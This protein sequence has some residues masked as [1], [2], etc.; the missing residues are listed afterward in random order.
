MGK[1]RAKVVRREREP[2][3]AERLTRVNDPY[4]LNRTMPA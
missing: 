3:G 1:V 4:H 2:F